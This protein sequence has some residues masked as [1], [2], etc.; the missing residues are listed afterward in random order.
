MVLFY[1]F[2]E[3]NFKFRPHSSSS[4]Y[5][6][7]ISY[8]RSSLFRNIMQHILAVSYRSFETTYWSHMRQSSNAVLDCLTSRCVMMKR[9]KGLYYTAAEAHNRMI[10]FRFITPCNSFNFPVTF[11]SCSKNRAI[12]EDA[13]NGMTFVK[14]VYGSQ[15]HIVNR[16]K[17]NQE[18]DFQNRAFAS[19][20]PTL[21]VRNPPALTQDSVITQHN[22]Q[23]KHRLN[24]IRSFFYFYR[25]TVHFEDSLIITYQ[26]MH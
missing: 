5:S 7:P 24:F 17:N 15:A 23:I 11:S 2:Y 26:Q 20:S 16:F 4:R 12:L 21:S 22:T 13:F 3:R 14:T 25:C 19:S 9:S 1:E 6:P 8:L 10:Y 18:E